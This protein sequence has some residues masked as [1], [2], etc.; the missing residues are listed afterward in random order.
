MKVYF[1][2]AG[3]GSADLIT[4]RG[5]EILSRCPVV[6]Y[7]GSLVSPEHLEF[8][9]DQAEK[10]VSASLT[11]EDIRSIL[12]SARDRNVDVAR[13]HTGDPSLYGAVR[14]QGELCDELGIEWEIVPGVSSAFAAA[15]RLG[16]EYT[17]PDGTQTL[18]FTRMEGRTTVPLSENLALLAEHRSSLAIFLS[19]QDI[20]K[21]AEQLLKVLPS[22][23]PVVVAVRVSW[24]D[25]KFIH[26]NLNDIVEKVRNA[27]VT[28]TA[29]ILVGEAI[30]SSGRRSRLYHGDF[31]HGYR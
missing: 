16:I 20:D 9:P 14:E 24:P 23:T 7:A 12:I 30:Q 1:I 25:E 27:G 5:R 17:V 21:V 4:I 2:G 22:S 3:P 15:A 26:G 29:L 18:I 8:A 31:S 28:R 10:H 11:L 13:L 19:V 6:I